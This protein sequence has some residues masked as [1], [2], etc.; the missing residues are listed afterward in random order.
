MSYSFKLLVEEFENNLHPTVASVIRKI[1]KIM[2]SSILRSKCDKEAKS[3]LA[4]DQE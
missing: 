1:D 2:M 3:K 4:S